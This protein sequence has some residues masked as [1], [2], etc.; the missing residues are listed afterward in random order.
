MADNLDI[1]GIADEEQPRGDKFKTRGKRKKPW[2]IESRTLH[3]NPTPGSVFWTLKLHEWYV[4]SRYET[5]ARR[6]QAHAALVR[7]DENG[8]M[9][10]RF[11]I[12]QEYRKVDP[13]DG[14]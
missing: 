14:T 12:I 8:H 13:D 5:R 9:R 2:A 4:F 3:D 1:K 11:G 10:S 6:D 7:K